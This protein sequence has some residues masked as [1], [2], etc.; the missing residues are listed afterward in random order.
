[1]PRAALETGAVDLVLPLH[2]IGKVLTEVVRGGELPRSRA[3]I[4]AATALFAGDGEVRQLLRTMDWSRTTLGEI[5][6]WPTS[7][8]T[9]LHLVLEL[10]QLYNDQ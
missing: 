1:M 6:G 8:Q 9:T 3:A 2:E 7:L 10:I 4:D 5:A